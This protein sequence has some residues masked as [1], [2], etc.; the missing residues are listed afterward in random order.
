[1]SRSFIRARWGIGRRCS[2][3]DFGAIGVGTTR[4]V[5][6]K[7]FLTDVVVGAFLGTALGL[8]IPLLRTKTQ[9]PDD[10]GVVGA[11]SPLISLGGV[12]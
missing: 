8:T 12:F 10:P 1:M 4:V 9:A 11:P 5:A 3:A 7:H 6:G 2:W